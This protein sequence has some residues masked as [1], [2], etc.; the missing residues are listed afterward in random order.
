[1]DTHHELFVRVEE[2]D[3]IRVQEPINWGFIYHTAW[4][5]EAWEACN[6]FAVN[7]SFTI[8]YDSK[9]D[10]VVIHVRLS[11]RSL[12]LDNKS[13]VVSAVAVKSE[14][15][16]REVLLFA[17][18]EVMFFHDDSGDRRVDLLESWWD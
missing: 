12:S 1:M 7:R 18:N 4:A 3:P 14:V 16:E 17:D 8:P 6:L 2:I 9:D 13:S 5:R 11:N 15:E 10:F